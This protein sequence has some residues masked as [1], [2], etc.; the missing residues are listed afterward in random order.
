MKPSI[1]Y[2]AATNKQNRILE[3]INRTFSFKNE[4]NLDYTILAWVPYLQIDIKRLERM[5][6]MVIK[7]VPSLR[8]KQ[9]DT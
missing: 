4:A 8:N 5:Q 6:R 2:P 3:L 7:L 1:Q 9:Y